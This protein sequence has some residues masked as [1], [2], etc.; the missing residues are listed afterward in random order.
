MSVIIGV[1]PGAAQTGIAVR[2]GD[3]LLHSNTVVRSGGFP[4]GCDLVDGSYLREIAE[5]LNGIHDE[6]TFTPFT[7]MAVE[8]LNSPS[9]HIGMT[10]PG[11]IIAA[12]V[13][14]GY[15]V[16]WAVGLMPYAIVPPSHHGAG[17]SGAYPAALLDRGGQVLKGGARRHERSAWDVAGT[18]R[19]FLRAQ[20]VAGA[21]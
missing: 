10:N 1:D 9:P 17:Y 6:V 21:R 12:G 4:R 3:E 15:V 14:L 11:S 18:G 8:G 7:G 20:S 13:V 5:H 16:R 19:L 2:R